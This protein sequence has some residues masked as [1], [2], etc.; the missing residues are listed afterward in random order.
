MKKKT[1]GKLTLSK[2]TIGL[3]SSPVLREAVG[4]WGTMET[5]CCNTMNQCSMISC[6]GY[7]TI[8]EQMN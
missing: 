5:Q 7:C 8:Q 1:S 2:E 4:A 3:L 6:H